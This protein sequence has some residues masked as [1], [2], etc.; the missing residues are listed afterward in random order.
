MSTWYVADG[1]RHPGVA[2]GTGSYAT[3]AAL[4]GKWVDFNTTGGVWATKAASG[5]TI[6]F[7][8]AEFKLTELPVLKA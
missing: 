5:D 7:L 8:D 4:A 3:T 2:L 1:V 6:V